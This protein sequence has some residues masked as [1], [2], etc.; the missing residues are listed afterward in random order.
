MTERQQRIQQLIDWAKETLVEKY[1]DKWTAVNQSNM[2]E[3]QKGHSYGGYY[4][5]TSW[6]EVEKQLKLEAR[7]R[8]GIS[9]TTARDYADIARHAIWDNLLSLTIS[10][11][12][13]I[14]IEVKPE[15]NAS[16]RYCY[17]KDKR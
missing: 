12:D 15:R 8:W 9:E 14:G 16:V 1:S 17:W 10:K 7:K 3:H 11:L 6:D 4:F 13:K 2:E 5:H